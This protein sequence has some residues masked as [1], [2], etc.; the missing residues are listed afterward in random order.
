M[1]LQSKHSGGRYDFV[2]MPKT[3]LHVHLEGTLEPEMLFRLAG[4]NHIPLP[5]K[6]PQELHELFSSVIFPVFSRSIIK[7]V[8]SLLRT[9]FLRSDQCLSSTRFRRWSDSY[10]IFFQSA[11]FSTKKD[12]ASCNHACVFS[13]VHDMRDRISCLYWVR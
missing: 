9:G 3:D 8:K 6:T 1:T 13:A 2:K 10:G 12:A 11:D 4:R 5:W 7:A